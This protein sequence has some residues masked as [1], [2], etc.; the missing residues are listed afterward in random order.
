MRKE[1]IGMIV[2]KILI[3]VFTLAVGLALPVIAY[4]L[5]RFLKCGRQIID[6]KI[7][8]KGSAAET[9]EAVEDTI[10][11]TTAFTAATIAFI[12]LGIGFLW[13]AHGGLLDGNAWLKGVFLDTAVTPLPLVGQASLIPIVYWTVAYWVSFT[14]GWIYCAVKEE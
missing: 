7:K 9:K 3:A 5:A 6:D 14:L 13:Y 4:P 12:V 2:F 1:E 11:H 8:W 10:T